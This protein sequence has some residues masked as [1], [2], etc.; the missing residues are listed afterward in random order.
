MDECYPL[1][2][3]LKPWS[4]SFCNPRPT[5]RPYVYLITSPRHPIILRVY[6][7]KTNNPIVDWCNHS[8]TFKLQTHMGVGAVS[9]VAAWKLP[10]SFFV[11]HSSIQARTD[12]SSDAHTT[13]TMRTNTVLQFVPLH[14][15]AM[16]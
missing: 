2:Q 6:W 4:H 7:L 5:R 14:K 8:L 9:H 13:L 16:I 10:K 3:S 12:S 1:V 15:W 11:D